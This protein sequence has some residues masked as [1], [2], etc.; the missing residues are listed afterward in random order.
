MSLYKYLPSEHVP[1]VLDRGE[2]LFR[3]LTYF[4]QQEGPVRGDT[5]EGIHKNHPGTDIVIENT[6]HGIRAEGKY[7]FLNSTNPDLVFCFC[8]SKLLSK[9]LM[10]EF[11]YDACI[12]I[13]KPYEFI[14][15][16]R[17]ALKGLISVH[18]IGLLAQPVHYYHPAE[19]TL[20]DAT[21]PTQIVFA[22]NESYKGQDEFR[23]SFGTRRAF[24]LVQQIAQ[25]HY[26]PYNDAMKG[27]CKEK[28]VR[29]RGLNDVAKV[30]MPQ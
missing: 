13:F 12:E 2:I 19:P 3:N 27:Q 22:K 28:I 15:R 18:P 5:Y 20:F 16:V 24:K 8:M 14:R 25:P 6:E 1:A 9:E 26:D 10:A 23:L 21:D 7:S 29:V 11:K 30:V 4:R 17:F